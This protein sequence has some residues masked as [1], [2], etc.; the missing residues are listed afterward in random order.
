V[1]SL[2][3]KI[4]S[5]GPTWYYGANFEQEQKDLIQPTRGIYSAYTHVA[6]RFVPAAS[7]K[8]GVLPS[9][10]TRSTPGIEVILES[11]EIVKDRLTGLLASAKT[12]PRDRKALYAQLLLLGEAYNT[13]WTP[14]YRSPNAIDQI[15]RDG[16]ALAEDFANDPKDVEASSS[17]P[18]AGPLGQAIV[19]T[20]PAIGTRLDVQVNIGSTKISRRQAWANTL[21]QSVDYWRTHRRGYTN[22]SMIVDINIYTANRALQL[23][24]PARAL[25][26]ARA[27]HYLYQA[28]GIEPW[29]GSDLP[30]GGSEEPYGGH[31]YLVTRKGLS[32][33]LGYVGTY[34]ETILSFTRDMVVLTGDEK[35]RAQLRKLQDAR[36]YFRYPGYD[37]DGNR[38][39]KLASEIDNRTA[40]YPLS[41]SAYSEPAIREAWWMDTAALLQ[42]DP[43]VV[44]AAQ[45]SVREGQY[46][47][48]IESRLKDPDTL[49]MMRNVDE[50][51]KVSQL[52][53]SQSR[54]P[55]TPG[56]PDFAFADEEN[57]VLALKHRETC[58]F[59]N[60][61]YRAERAVNRV[62]RVFEVTPTITWLATVRPDV[63]VVKSGE[64]YE[65]PDW[66]DRIRDVGH[67][68]PGEDIHQAWAGEIMPIARRPEDA[69]SPKYG[70][71][72]P[73]LGKAAF[74]SLRYG[75]YL[76]GMNTTANQ[77]YNLHVPPGYSHAPEL[78]SGKEIELIGDIAVPP[79]STVVLYLGKPNTV[80]H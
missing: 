5:L 26:E 55:M 49:G 35:L 50:W 60:F 63:E 76:I 31:Y 22:Q 69:G 46:F 1:T 36:L 71:W 24:D 32:R 23:I 8:Q 61:Y 52:P 12:S 10:R 29:L 19:E 47:A 21:Q 38:C 59:I 42:D 77:S 53:Q 48:Y 57:A 27:L 30:G 56:Q 58:L 14:A 39:M 73:F 62:A 4:V 20:W 33:E 80:S 64:T 17:W 2:D 11:E 15:V 37:A 51:K 6:P 3:L 16:D 74:Y 43:M 25:P 65:R 13:R 44:G 70:D 9:A 41:G 75:D 18:G 40:H 79:L 7:E 28:T 34:G 72:G 67:P 68:P 45:Q 66:I 78:I 54:L